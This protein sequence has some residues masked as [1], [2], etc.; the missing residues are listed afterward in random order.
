MISQ[1][2]QHTPFSAHPRGHYRW[3]SQHAPALVNSRILSQYSSPRRSHTL[4]PSPHH[5]D[6]LMRPSEP[7]YNH[8][9]HPYPPYRHRPPRP[10]TPSTLDK[11]SNLTT[12]F[13]RD[14]CARPHSPPYLNTPINRRTYQ[15]KNLSQHPRRPHPR[16][17]TLASHESQL[18]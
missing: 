17:Q 11:Q 18:A 2:I 7:P 10:P 12:R 3:E 15:L 6:R 9:F 8:L 1:T 4:F 14:N 13:S 16:H 5:S